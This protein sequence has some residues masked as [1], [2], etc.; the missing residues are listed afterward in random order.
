MPKNKAA[1]TIIAAAV[2]ITTKITPKMLLANE[3][4]AEIQIG[5]EC[6]RFTFSVDESEEPFVAYFLELFTRFGVRTH[7]RAPTLT[8]THTEYEIKCRRAD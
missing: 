8:H 1:T 2:A 3:Q 4:S 5:T 6:Y 7:I